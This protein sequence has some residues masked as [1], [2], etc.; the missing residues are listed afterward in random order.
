MFTRRNSL[1]LMGAA[2][3]ATLIPARAKAEAAIH[4]VQMLNDHPEDDKK[5]FVFFPEIV[6]AQ[7]GDVI[8]FLSVDSN[9]NSEAFKN[10]LP[11]GAPHWKSKLGDDFDLTVETP[12]AYGYFCTPH[13]SWG[14]VGLMLVGDVSGNYEAIKAERQRGKAKANFAALFEEADAMLAAERS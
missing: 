8:R 10:M 1:A 2:A 13:K 12:G 14:M 6:R 3:A 11:E 5:L 7:P 4:E 9:H